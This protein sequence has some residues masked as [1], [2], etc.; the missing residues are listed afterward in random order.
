MSA[1]MTR[2]GTL[3][4]ALAI[5][6]TVAVFSPAVLGGVFSAVAKS[7][8]NKT[9]ARGAEHA[10]V[11][12]A[13]ADAMRAAAEAAMRQQMEGLDR[14]TLDTIAKRYGAYVNRERLAS[15]R[16]CPSCFLDAKAYDRALARVDPKL[17][18]EER[19]AVVGF[20]LDK[21]VVNMDRRHL[22]RTVAHERLHQLASPAFRQHGGAALDE[23]ATEYF[24]ARIY[25]G[26]GLPEHAPAYPEAF[27][28]FEQ[29]GARFGEERLAKAYFGGRV[30]ELARMVDAELGRGAFASI[31]RAAEA[32]RFDEAM[33]IVRHR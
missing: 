20:Y 15:A 25:P 13:S 12:R 10:A 2:S 23:G 28:L 16:G 19:Q 32:N 14:K 3:C 26:M 30:T 22:T 17:S 8:A 9:L 21:T 6:T 33:Q 4:A 7:A 31:A 5:G 29:L 27:R 11:D 1:F 18:P 24:A